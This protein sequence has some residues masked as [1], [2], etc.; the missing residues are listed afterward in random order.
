MNRQ[1]LK[2]TL[3]YRLDIFW[4]CYVLLLMLMFC[5]PY[6][7]LFFHSLCTL[8]NG[9]LSCCL[10]LTKKQF[11]I[12]KSTSEHSFI[13]FVVGWSCVSPWIIVLKLWLFTA[14]WG[15]R[16]HPANP[17]VQQ[18]HEEQRCVSVLLVYLTIAIWSWR[19]AILTP[20]NWSRW[21]LCCCVM[22]CIQYPLGGSRSKFVETTC[23][24]L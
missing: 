4:V 18:P 14:T 21:C 5:V 12:C 8:V 3:N 24:S 9:L 11:I 13:C 19:H 6:P 10:L 23:G 17:S 2:Q 15:W 16:E 1:K 20:N 22:C 7:R